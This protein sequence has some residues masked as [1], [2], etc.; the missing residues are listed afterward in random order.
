MQ[1]DKNNSPILPYKF[2]CLQCYIEILKSFFCT[3][4]PQGCIMNK[5]DDYVVVLGSSHS[6]YY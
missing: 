2:N 5:E 6:F 3:F 4:K 1:E